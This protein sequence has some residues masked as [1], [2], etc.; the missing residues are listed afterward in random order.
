MCVV[1]RCCSE[2]DLQKK[3]HLAISE[4]EQN[5]L[6]YKVLQ[7]ENK[8]LRSDLVKSNK[9][10]VAAQSKVTE[11]EAKLSVHC[12]GKET[13]LAKIEYLQSKLND[14]NKNYSALAGSISAVETNFKNA[15]NLQ[16]KLEYCKAHSSCIV[17]DLQSQIKE[18]NQLIVKLKAAQLK[19]PASVF[20]PSKYEEKVFEEH[21]KLVTFL[22][23]QL[24][25]KTTE[26]EQTVK[27]METAQMSARELSEVFL[28]E[29]KESAEKIAN[30]EE[31]AFRLTVQVKLVQEAVFAKEQQNQTLAEKLKISDE[32]AQDLQGELEIL[33]SL[34]SKETSDTATET[35]IESNDVACQNLSQIQTDNIAALDEMRR[36]DKEQDANVSCC[37]TVESKECQTDIMSPFRSPSPVSN[38]QSP[39]N[40]KH[41]PLSTTSKRSLADSPKRNEVGSSSQKRLKSDFL[42]IDDIS[43]SPLPLSKRLSLKLTSPI[44]MVLEEDCKMTTIVEE[45]LKIEDCSPE[46]TQYEYMETSGESYLTRHPAQSFPVEDWL[47]VANPE[48]SF[49]NVQSRASYEEDNPKTPEHLISTAESKCNQTLQS[50]ARYRND[51]DYSSL[52]S[53]D[54]SPEEKTPRKVPRKV[55]SVT[56][57]K[58]SPLSSDITS[59]TPQ[60]YDSGFLENV[61]QT[62]SETRNVVSVFAD[63]SEEESPVNCVRNEVRVSV[64]RVLKK[65][66]RR[67]NSAVERTETL[68]LYKASLSKS[69]KSKLAPSSCSL[70]PASSTTTSRSVFSGS[71][72]PVTSPQQKGTNFSSTQVAR[73]VKN[74]KTI[75]KG[76]GEE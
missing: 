71:R 20:V 40:F 68:N 61:P 17:K 2:R 38:T 51:P 21:N 11:V 22:K 56:S 23:E 14:L 48:V 69:P 55:E 46:R 59:K 57:I 13:F 72:L 52:E 47:T 6:K 53:S 32:Q 64:E 16:R 66:Y 63:S 70:G 27:L 19:D 62:P 65:A 10:K 29:R 1:Q 43:P 8:T 26:V 41:S 74:A 35:C 33:K 4:Q 49:Q 30:L 34:I 36:R 54:Q 28:L 76:Q 12:K 9:E 42:L 75:V 24:L 67:V 50:G 44:Q 60:Q 39:I 45:G 5:Q 18:K 58:E 7:E 73:I 15:L 3:Y 31:E 37:P 25:E